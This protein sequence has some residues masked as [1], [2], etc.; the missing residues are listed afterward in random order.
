MEHN[1]N[2]PSSRHNRNAWLSCGITL[3]I[4]PCIY[5]VFLGLNNKKIKSVLEL[6]EKENNTLVSSKAVYMIPIGQSV[7]Q[8]S[9]LFMGVT[10][11][12]S[13]ATSGNP[14]FRVVDACSSETCINP[15]TQ[16]MFEQNDQT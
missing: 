13:M 1:M 16:K 7:I 6:I 9:L 5:I 12:I 4:M 15:N 10:G 14:E 3:C 2:M 11:A 8:M